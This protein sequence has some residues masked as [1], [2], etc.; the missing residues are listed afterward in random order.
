MKYSRT[1]NSYA[2]S[3]LMACGSLHLQIKIEFNSLR[4]TVPD[5]LNAL[6]MTDKARQIRLGPELIQYVSV[7][8]SSQHTSP[9][10]STRT[11][12]ASRHV[13]V[14]AMSLLFLIR[15]NA[16]KPCPP[17]SNKNA[18]KK[19]ARLRQENETGVGGQSLFFST[20]LAPIWSAEKKVRNRKQRAITQLDPSFRKLKPLEL[21]TSVT[22]Q[23]EVHFGPLLLF[24]YSKINHSSD[25]VLCAVNKFAC[26]PPFPSHI[27]SPSKTQWR[28]GE[29]Y[30]LPMSSSRCC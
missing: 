30:M 10:R 4:Y 11:W 13:C 21:F 14:C 29:C 24:H 22:S 19:L 28:D 8:A 12:E 18:D 23:H 2:I 9:T 1:H 17:D 25:L 3:S 27:I 7:V 15:P 26:E 16:M 20:H 5:D 6:Q